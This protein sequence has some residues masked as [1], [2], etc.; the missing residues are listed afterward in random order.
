MTNNDQRLEPLELVNDLFKVLNERGIRYC[1]WKS[2]FGLS[3]GMSGETD[4]DLL[5]ARSH[6]RLFVEIL[7]E[8]NFKPFNP[9]PSRQYSGIVDYLGFDEESGKLVHL[10]VHY[11]LVLGEQYIKNYQLPLED[12]LLD[13][14]YLTHGVRIP[15]PELEV[16]LLVI[17][18]LL[19]YRDEDWLRDR[20]KVGRQ[21]GLTEDTIREFKH[22]LPQV[23]NQRIE[24]FIDQEFPF[25]SPSVVQDFLELIEEPTD[26]GGKLLPLR[27]TVRMDLASFQRYSSFRAKTKYFKERIKR[28]WI[29]R[30]LGIM[31]WKL[32]RG[33]TPD[34]GGVT[35]AFVG[36]DGSGKTTIIREISTWLSWQLK[37]KNY[38][39]GSN[40]P[41]TIARI[42]KGIYKFTYNSRL[43]VRR[44]IGDRNFIHRIFQE[45]TRFT[46]SV[47]YLAEARDLQRRYLD[48]KRK[49]AQGSIVLFERYPLVCHSDFSYMLDGPRI[50][51][52]YNGNLGL[53]S[54][55]FA[56]IEES[57]HTSFQSPDHTFLFHVEP[58]VSLARKPDHEEDMIRSKYHAIQ[59]IDRDGGHI[60]D[61]DGNLPY[62]EVLS[63]VKNLCWDFI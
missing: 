8:H 40:Q 4:L 44:L 29:L 49:S 48:G 41:A 45:M 35:L 63:Q 3:K 6:Q 11:H 16:I 22:L 53:I 15:V 42:L 5:V 34:S 23:N 50:E 12:L 61:I 13:N 24:F 26:I 33:K 18:S 51:H 27:K 54:K 60:I 62:N 56:N 21:K 55:R 37:V 9:D 7:L 36:I 52:L 30:R 32:E 57:I 58:E 19:K 28:H 46:K 43:V 14:T 2:T 10:H 17:R 59:G 38:Y 20:L 31:K 47:R 1:H 25:L 39:M